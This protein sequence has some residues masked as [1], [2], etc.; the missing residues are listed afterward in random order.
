MIFFFFFFLN[1]KVGFKRILLLPA[2]APSQDLRLYY[3]SFCFHQQWKKCD[4]YLQ[5]SSRFDRGLLRSVTWFVV[6]AFFLLSYFYIDGKAVVRLAFFF[7]F[8][9][10]CRSLSIAD[11]MEVVQPLHGTADASRSPINKWRDENHP[12]G[13]RSRFKKLLPTVHSTFS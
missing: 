1:F 11:C 12:A 10:L 4:V 7:F 5:N 9:F 2:Q 13:E 6:D 3:I 8:F